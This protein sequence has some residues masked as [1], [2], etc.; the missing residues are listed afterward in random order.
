MMQFENT[1]VHFGQPWANQILDWL[2]TDTKEN[3][4]KLI[5]DPGHR[6][7]FAKMGWD[8]PGAITYK[9]NSYGFRADEF[10]GGPYMMALGC[11]YSI[12]IGL[13]DETT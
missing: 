11:S 10:N 1:P 7:Y 6:E 2:P 12:G 8:Q 3:Y 9:F 13:P 4:E 5:Q